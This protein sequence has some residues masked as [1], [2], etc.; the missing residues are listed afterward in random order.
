MAS[1]ARG[2]LVITH[3]LPDGLLASRREEHESSLTWGGT[4]SRSCSHVSP[5]IARGRV[6]YLRVMGALEWPWDQEGISWSLGVDP[7][8][9]KVYGVAKVHEDGSAYFTVPA[10]QNLFFQALDEDF[11]ALQEMATFINLMPGE[12]RSCIGCHEPRKGAPDASRIHPL[13]LNHPPQDLAPQP[14]DR[15]SVSAQDFSGNEGARC[16]DRPYPPRQAEEGHRR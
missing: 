4:S 2:R 8:R 10:E 16:P 11:M 1:H 13:A 5:G 12:Q 14:G 3:D 15:Y 9:K 7:H 6:R